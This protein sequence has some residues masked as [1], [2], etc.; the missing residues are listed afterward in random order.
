MVNPVDLREK[1]TPDATMDFTQATRERTNL[2]LIC[3]STSDGNRAH[4][5]RYTHTQACTQTGA[6]TRQSTSP[7]S[8]YYITYVLDAGYK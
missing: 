2:L 6:K 7:R 8:G 3:I 1:A 4:T 5:H